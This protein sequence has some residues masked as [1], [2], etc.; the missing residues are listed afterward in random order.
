MLR[1][2]IVHTDKI[3]T[4]LSHNTTTIPFTTSPVP[5]PTEDY[6][7]NKVRGTEYE[8]DK[9]SSSDPVPVRCGQHTDQLGS[10]SKS[11][12]SKNCAVRSFPYKKVPY[13]AVDSGG[14]TVRGVPAW[15]FR[16]LMDE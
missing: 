9:S 11:K 12:A 13:H 7:L 5:T 14:L 1:H 15:A 6:T 16:F 4:L 10:S 2:A 8:P 3:H